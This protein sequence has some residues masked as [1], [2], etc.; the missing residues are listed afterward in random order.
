MS[1]TGNDAIRALL[2]IT[3]CCLVIVVVSVDSSDSS[4]TTCHVCTSLLPLLPL[5]FTSTFPRHRVG[6]ILKRPPLLEITP[7]VNFPLRPKLIEAE[8]NKVNS[9]YE[10]PRLNQL[11]TSQGQA[12][13]AGM[14]YCID[15]SRK[16]T[17]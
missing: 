3:S 17:P 11:K 14:P 5:L 10:S 15:S 1:E 16:K 9:S 7:P 6:Q 8:K 12:Q 4:L 2:S 13:H